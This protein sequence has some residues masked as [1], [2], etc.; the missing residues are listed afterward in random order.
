MIGTIRRGEA[1]ELRSAEPETPDHYAQILLKEIE[2]RKEDLRYLQGYL[3]GAPFSAGFAEEQ[4]MN[5]NVLDDLKDISRMNLASVIVSAT[6]DRLGPAGFRTGVDSDETGDREAMEAFTKDEMNVKATYGMQLAC[7]YRS[8]YLVVDPLSKRQNIIPPTNAAVINDLFGEPVAALTLQRDRYLNREILK[9]YI[10]EQNAETGEAT[11]QFSLFLASREMG[12][13]DPTKGMYRGARRS[14]KA[15]SYSSDITVT[16]YDTEVPLNDRLKAGWVWW[17]AVPKKYERIPVTPLVN[18]DGKA[19]FE[20]HVDG[21]DRVHYGIFQRNLIVTMQALRQRAVETAENAPL[22]R[23]DD[24]GNPINYSDQFSAEPGAVWVMPPGA[25]LWESSG[26]DISSLHLATRDDIKDLFSQSYTN[27]AYM[28]DSVNQSAAGANNQQDGYVSKI[29]DRRRRFESR[30]ARHMSIYFEMNDDLERADVSKI[31][32]I[33]PPIKIESITDSTASFAAL[34]AQ[35]FPLRASMREALKMTP[36]EI[37]RVEQEMYEERINKAVEAAM[38][39]ATPIESNQA[40]SS[41]NPSGTSTGAGG[42]GGSATAREQAN[43][44]R[45]G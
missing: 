11:G 5:R 44:N 15:R 4:D 27:M 9:L 20:D 19:E 6:T 1:L 7:S 36:D 39:G 3:E 25:K 17:K 2:G 18:K 22:P 21:I 33:W 45:K 24:M 29:Q 30:L 43:S 42:N 37:S 10:R 41:G 34:R 35:Q 13:D 16:N 23:T 40:Q 31:Q 8:S 32:V 26:M 14:Q 38:N 12:K 28:S